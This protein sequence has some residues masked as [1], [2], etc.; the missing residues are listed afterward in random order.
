MKIPIHFNYTEVAAKKAI[1]IQDSDA[2]MSSDNE[3]QE[4]LKA[5]LRITADRPK[6]PKPH[7]QMLDPQVQKE[8]AALQ[9]HP[10]N[11]QNSGPGPGVKNFK[12]M[13]NLTHSS[14]SQRFT[15]ERSS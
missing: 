9:G 11:I 12:M 5:L 14:L 8:I 4:E 15:A 2:S 13:P 1:V 6:N 10:E 3:D 7:K